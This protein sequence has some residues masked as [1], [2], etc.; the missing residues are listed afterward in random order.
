MNPHAV[1]HDP[2]ASVLMA[3]LLSLCLLLCGWAWRR[4]SAPY[5]WW[6]A[7]ALAAAAIGCGAAVLHPVSLWL[8]AWLQATAVLL[9]LAMV[10]RLGQRR[11]SAVLATA[12]V[13][14]AVALLAGASAV[15]PVVWVWAICA[16]AMAASLLAVVPV[17]GRARARNRAEQA[18][19]LVFMLLAGVVA[20]LAVAA[21]TSRMVPTWLVYAIAVGSLAHAV[22]LLV[23]VWVDVRRAGW[24]QLLAQKAPFP[25]TGRAAFA[26]HCGPFPV[27]RGFTAMVLCEVDDVP[28]HHRA[29]AQAI[30]QQVLR[31]VAQQLQ[32]SLR[33]GDVVAHLGGA[34]FAL[35]L[36]D[37]APEAAQALMAR[38]THNL[39]GLHWGRKADLRPLTMHC[40]VVE[41]RPQ[42]SVDHALHR[43]DVALYQLQD[44]RPEAPAETVLPAH[45]WRTL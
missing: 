20:A 41:V 19:F 22:A 38:I 40:A 15:L 33:E 24:R 10:A 6:E 11:P 32:H 36:R 17:V 1:L 30:A 35:A 31:R 28:R 4:R 5:A 45:H 34:E 18:G 42:D 12:S 14:A 43:A 13:V 8:G 23:S 2:S 39:A 9:S 37:I 21:W 3:V 44:P 16:S 29:Q 25:L 7:A 26:A 27:E